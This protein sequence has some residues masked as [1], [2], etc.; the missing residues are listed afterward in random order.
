MSD[1][2]RALYTYRPISIS[3]EQLK[4]LQELEKM[5]TAK[6]P[7]TIS[8]GFCPSH[9]KAIG[10]QQTGLP[11]VFSAYF[12]RGTCAAILADE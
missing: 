10:N 5:V 3:D 8:L 4:D 7:N 12:A 11:V 6:E 9:Q 1:I 2:I